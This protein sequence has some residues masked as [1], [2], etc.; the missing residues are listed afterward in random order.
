MAIDAW[1]YLNTAGLQMPKDPENKVSKLAVYRVL[2]NLVCHA[3]EPD[4]LSWVGSRKQEIECDM[5][6]SS[7]ILARLLLEKHGWLVRTGAVHQAGALEYK[8]I[9]PGYEPS[10]GI[11]KQTTNELPSGVSSGIRSGVSSNAKTE[12]NM[13]TTQA[14]ALFELVVK[15]QLQHETWRKNKDPEAFK[16]KHAAEYL[17]VCET[18]LRHFPGGHNDP[19]VVHWVLGD[20]FAK[21]KPDYK[22][23]PSLLQILANR[24]G[25][26]GGNLVSKEPDFDPEQSR[27]SAQQVREQFRQQCKQNEQNRQN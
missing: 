27:Q 17:P 15:R 7:V 25:L 10:S 6:R 14:Q 5:A 21:T 22:V 24:Y 8:V 19:D 9:L 18:A 1:V 4:L 20:L 12:Q 16:K 23:S 2:S 11:T 13:N 26:P 3:Q